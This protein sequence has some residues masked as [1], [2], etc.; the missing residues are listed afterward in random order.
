MRL[1]AERQ[2]ITGQSSFFSKTGHQCAFWNSRRRPR[3]VVFKSHYDDWSA[4]ARSRALATE[5]KSSI[6]TCESRSDRP[7]LVFVD[8]FAACSRITAC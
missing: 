3:E 1:A 6:Q 8:D 2:S 5:V 4:S 7:A